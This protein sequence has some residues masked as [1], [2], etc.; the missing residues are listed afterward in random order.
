MVLMANR[1]ILPAAL[2]LP[3]RGGAER[4][5]GQGG[6]RRRD[7][8][9]EAARRVHQDSSTSFRKRTDELARGARPHGG[10]SAE[11]HAKY[12]RD[13][14][15]PAMAAL[16]ELGDKHRDDGAVEHV[17]AADLP[18]DAVHQ[19][20]GSPSLGRRPGRL[21]ASPSAR[22]AGIAPA[23]RLPYAAT[24]HRLSRRRHHGSRRYTAK[25]ITVLEG[26]EPVRKRPGMYIG[27]VGTAGLHHLVWEILDNAI[28]EAMNGYASTIVVTLHA[29][30]SSITVADDGRGIPVDKHPK[31]G[32]SAL[33]VIFTVLHA[34]GKFEAR[35]LQD[36][37]R[38]ARR[39]RQR[40]QRAVEGAGRDRAARRRTVG[41][42]LPAGQA[43]GRAGQE[44]GPARGTGTTVCV[45]SR[46]GDLPAHRVRRRAP[47]RA[48]RDRRATCTAASSSPSS[49]RRPATR[50]TFVARGRPR[51]LPAPARRRAQASAPSTRRRSRWPATARQRR[52][53]RARAAVDRGDRRAR[54]QL[55]QRHPDRLGRH[56][57]E[58]PPRRPRQG[59]A[60]L[61]RD[62]QPVAEGRDA[63]R[64]GHAR[65]PGRRAQRL[66]PGAAVP[67]PDE[68]S[69]EQPR[70]A[71]RGRRA[72]CGR[73]SSTG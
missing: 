51:R 11:K 35:Q 26:L 5:G 72:W 54:P 13:T 62:A 12:M 41:A 56:A 46:S 2:E 73:R 53:R 70:G 22:R 50:D 7:G 49:T 4:G 25:D 57:R 71:R 44:A 43:A 60:Q 15:I 69:A 67:G 37:R 63:D 48:P 20:G 30:G 14:V 55:R 33:E 64:R 59:G 1:Y 58:R 52:P 65:G 66:R 23:S 28:D 32:K 61:H 21:R 24:A 9:E 34:G 6:G 38:P 10:G 45:P 17:A 47:A 16:R 36:R 18:R 27:G 68:G 31:T 40:R 29:D 19:V 8:G 42:A 3:D 39:R